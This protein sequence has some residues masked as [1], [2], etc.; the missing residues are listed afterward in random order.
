M[1]SRP[2]ASPGLSGEL[3]R[4]AGSYRLLIVF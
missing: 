3:A 1:T 4:A 2:A